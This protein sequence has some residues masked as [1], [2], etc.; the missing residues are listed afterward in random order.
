MREIAYYDDSAGP[1]PR[2]VGVGICDETP[3]AWSAVYFYY[4]P[5]YAAQSPGVAHV[6]FQMKL[7][8]SRG[9]AH[10]YLGYFVT[11]CPS[12]RY[13]ARFR[14]N[15]RLVGWPAPGEEP[16]WVTAPPEV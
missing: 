8:A 2:L 14:P 4:D 1:R 16:R 13:K 12:M 15:E 5:D 11:G 3:S 6:L 7:A 10:V 9:L